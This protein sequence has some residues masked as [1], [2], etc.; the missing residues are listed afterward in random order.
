MKTVWVVWDPLYEKV[1]S[2]H[3]TEEGAGGKCNYEGNKDD[4]DVCPYYFFEYQ[5][6]MVEE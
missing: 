6:F 1:V 3:K 5:E 2:V 4:R